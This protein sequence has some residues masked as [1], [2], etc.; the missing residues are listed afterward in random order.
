MS[1]IFKSEVIKFIRYIIIVL[2][3][4]AWVLYA[5]P[6]M[7]VRIPWVQS[8]VART[9]TAVL[10]EKLGVPVHVERVNIK[11]LRHLVLE[12][13]YLEDQQGRVMFTANHV[14]AGFEL[15]PLLDGK[16]VFNT[17]RLFGPNV[18]LSRPTAQDPLNLQF[19][20]DAFASKDTVPKHPNIDLRFNT[21]LI[22]QGHF[23]YDIAEAPLTPGRFNAK[24]VD[25]HDVSAKISIKALRNDSINAQIKRLS[26]KEASGFAL[27]RLALTVVGNP[28]SLFLQ[29]FEIKLPKSTLRIADAEIALPQAGIDTSFVDS[30]ALQLRINPSSICLKDLSAFVPAFHNFTDSVVLTAKAHGDVNHIDLENLTLKYSNKMLL[31]GQMKLQNVTQP[32]SAYLL[33]RINKLYLTTNGMEDLVNNF[34]KE[35]HS[36]PE[37][38]ERLGTINFTGEIGG[39]IHQLTAHGKL[40]TAVGS[41]QTDIAFASSE[42]SGESIKGQVATNEIHLHQLLADNNPF[43]MAQCNIELDAKRPPKGSFAGNIR[44]NVE[45]FDYNGY[46]Y[47]DLSVGGHFAPQA[48][49]GTVRWDDENGSLVANGLLENK[50]ANSVFNFTAALNHFR[51]DRLNLT[52][53]YEEP[54]I[55]LT[56]NADF[57]GNNIDNING[58]IDI[59]SLDF[60]TA[61]S[62]FFL[63]H[64]GIEAGGS[65]ADRNLTVSSELINAEVRGAYSFATIGPS[66]MNTLKGYIPA[67]INFSYQPKRV[68][69]NNFSLVLTVNNTEA[70]SQTLK[71]PFTVIEPVRVLG[72]YNNNYN[73]FRFEANLPRFNVG[74]ACFEETFLHCSNASD[75]IDLGVKATQFNALGLRNYLSLTA[76]AQE[77]HLNT[78]LQWANNKERTFK[79]DLIAS[80]QF[81]TD[82]TEQGKPSLLTEIKL[83]ETPLVINDTVWQI[84]PSTISIEQ[85]KVDIDHFSISR[86]REYLLMNGVVSNDITDTLNLEL[87]NIELSYIFDVLNIPVLQF[88]GKATGKFNICDLMGSR[89]LNTDLEVRD[90]S[91]NQVALGRLNLFSEWDDAQRGILML[92]TIYANDTTW[93]DV[94]GYIYPVK[95]P[96]REAG[97]SLYF[98][99]NDVNVAFLHPFMEKVAENIQGRGFGNVHLYG[100]FHSLSVEGDAYVRD[101]GMGIPF[102]NTYYTFSDSIHMDSTSIRAKNIMVYDKYHNTAKVNLQV[103]HKHFRNIDFQVNVQANNMLAYDAD[104][105]HNPLIYGTVFGSG[106]VDI[107]GNEQLINF[108]IN[109]QSRPKTHVYMDFMGNSTATE[110]DFITFVDRRKRA[111]ADAKND[112]QA[113]AV[114]ATT[115]PSAGAEMRMNFLLDITPDAYI[116]LIMD[117]NAGDKIKGTG[118][119]SM[120]IQYGTTGDIRMYGN[121]VIQEGVYNFSLQQLIH[122][123][124]KIREGSLVSFNGD[125]FDANLDI[126]AIYNL[127]ANLSDLDQSL[128]LESPRTNVPVNCV[129]LL[130]GMLRQ[131]NINFDLE[132][133]GS[134]EELQRQMKSLIDTDDMM[135]RQIIYLLVLN[136]F[137][138]PEYTGQNSNDFTAVASSALSSQLSSLLSS[139]TDKV[140]IG[141]NIRAAEDWGVKDTEV[142]MLLSSQLL[143]NRLL[144]NGNFGYKNNA[145]QKNAFI[146]EFDLEYKLNRSGD[147]RLKA[148]NHMN[149]MYQYLKQALTT[150]GVGIVFK[151]DFSNL[152]DLFRRNYRVLRPSAADST[153]IVQPTDSVRTK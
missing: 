3:V 9:A 79:A 148:Y 5:V 25:V 10:S 77:D 8:Q 68:E 75:R 82:T 4:A 122:K 81:T 74:K 51:P 137:Y 14:A 96:L 56:L 24:H 107:Q 151:K 46:I 22:H 59:D 49:N 7:M 139:I 124:F 102:L 112:P 54:E 138:T 101:G 121:Y 130:D 100:P 153:R 58:T 142:E 23:R 147:I 144:F 43:G 39:Y 133:P 123:D 136:K 119:G 65:S 126:N 71:L 62:R 78:H 128:A 143:N 47:K 55:S 140:Q 29:Q 53:K 150:Q 89:M 57:V 45:R 33:G 60:A 35:K 83:A 26:L 106:N 98:D 127:T 152:S 87:N 85:G 21:V 27:D 20:I 108:D 52:Q 19:V 109:M 105:K 115:P 34:R 66:L 131:P 149:D 42:E 36:L 92:G 15:W 70:L 95:S 16:F 67:L 72:S 90:F 12:G 41:L 61:Q 69:E 113:A 28:D 116:E 146:G 99:A 134:N 110:Y 44:L 50:G 88:A 37:T 103:N 118:S 120:Q 94:S 38:V 80:T 18:S 40:S 86:N 76:D 64:L 117:P 73:R 30:A 97:L 145:T 1:I 104:V 125:P 48:F 31:V 91:F 2:L 93:S 63:P 135:T 6:A 114:G 17:V 84:H 13:L 129:L 111:E 32:K 11:W 141:T 132:L